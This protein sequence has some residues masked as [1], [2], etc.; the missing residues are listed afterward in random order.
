MSR[1]SGR[2][3]NNN[4]HDYANL[5]SSRSPPASDRNGMPQV[6]RHNS[7][8]PIHLRNLEQ[9][10]RSSAKP[11]KANKKEKSHYKAG[12]EFDL[13]WKY[14]DEFLLL[15]QSKKQSKPMVSNDRSRSHARHP[16]HVSP[17]GSP[18]QSDPS[19]GH[20]SSSTYSEKLREQRRWQAKRDQLDY[21][22]RHYT[23]WGELKYLVKSALINRAERK[24][25]SAKQHGDEE[26]EAVKRRAEKASYPTPIYDSMRTHF[27]V[28]QSSCRNANGVTQPEPAVTR[29]RKDDMPTAHPFVARKTSPADQKDR[30]ALSHH[31]SEVTQPPRTHD[32]VHFADQMP[33]NTS[34][35]GNG[36]SQLNSANGRQNRATQF[37]DFMEETSRLPDAP[38]PPPPKDT[39]IRGTQNAKTAQRSLNPL[40]CNVCGAEPGRGFAFSDTNLWLCPDCLHP[41]SPYEAPPSPTEGRKPLPYHVASSSQDSKAAHLALGKT[42]SPLSM[43]GLSRHLSE[44]EAFDFHEYDVSPLSER[45]AF[46]VDEIKPVLHQAP[47]LA[48]K[49]TIAQPRKEPTTIWTGSQLPGIDTAKTSFDPAGNPLP[50]RSH[51]K[52]KQRES[53]T[54]PTAG[55]KPPF[56]SRSKKPRAA[57]SIYPDE[58]ALPAIPHI[59]LPP[60]PAL[61]VSKGHEEKRKSFYPMTPGVSSSRLPSPEREGTDGEK[62]TKMKYENPKG[63]EGRSDARETLPANRRSSF[64]GFYAPILREHGM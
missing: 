44:D 55:I 26:R 12:S 62:L 21:E 17:A 25:V 24:S 28:R 15:G 39:Q 20:Q 4:N 36:K 18:Q 1:S 16:S 34:T 49:P 37:S 33:F 11:K 7:H 6:E 50:A 61:F 57:S 51:A 10:S 48:R 22:A 32:S 23:L 19:D 56:P 54:N 60:I 3:N 47:T 30:R 40:Q 58:D 29:T 52:G 45:G 63:E 13:M 59:P 43:I 46:D 27:S 8:R 42:R 35:M 53:S 38:P 41:A 31:A 14:I 2:S 9:A 5:G 64:Y